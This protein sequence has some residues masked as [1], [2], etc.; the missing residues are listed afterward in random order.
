MTASPPRT[1][2]GTLAAAVL[3]TLAMGGSAH[4]AAE[5]G[6]FGPFAG[7]F[8]A[9]AVDTGT[10]LG[11]GVTVTIT[12]TETVTGRFTENGPPAFG[13]HDHGTSTIDGRI[14]YPDGR[15]VLGTDT[16]HFDDNATS[17]DQFTSVAAGHGSGTLYDAGGTP[18]G[19]VTI[20]DLD[21]ITYRDVNGNHEPDAGE[22]RADIV[23]FRV[24]CP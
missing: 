22:I 15:Y 4:G 9:T 20:H 7:P 2:A 1:L 16:A 18:L 5:T 14:D 17:R 11:P 10:C 8:A 23:R 6:T 13:F 19:Q 24:S 3:G 12:G 21:H